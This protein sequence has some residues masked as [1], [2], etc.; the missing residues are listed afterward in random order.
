MGDYLIDANTLISAHR[1][2]Y[3][4]GVAKSFWKTIAQLAKDQVLCSIDKV[5]SEIYYNEDPLTQWCKDNID[6]SFWLPS[7]TCLLEYQRVVQWAQR[8]SDHY[9]GNAIKNFMRTDNADPWLIAFALKESLTLVTEEVANPA[10]K[11]NIKIPDA[12]KPFNVQ[13]M[14]LMDMFEDFGVQF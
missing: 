7:S 9:T 2:S 5:R 13:S 6:D 4:L 3:R 12:C 14:N 11:N 10:R 1:S 8:R